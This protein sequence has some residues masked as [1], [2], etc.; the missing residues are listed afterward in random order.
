[1]SATVAAV[2]SGDAA[3]GLG[4]SYRAPVLASLIGP[5]VRNANTAG[6]QAVTL[7]GSQFGPPGYQNTSDGYI[8]VSYTGADTGLT[9][10]AASCS[11]IS[12]TAMACNTGP[13]IGAGEYGGCG[14]WP[15]HRR[16]RVW[17][18]W[19]LARA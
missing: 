11:V 16:R 17:G 14:H 12:S 19:P 1:M 8:S 18:V 9:F 10:R 13:G 3:S 7:I 2:T 4:V 15:G 6:G 5:G